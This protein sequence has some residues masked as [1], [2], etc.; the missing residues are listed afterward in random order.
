MSWGPSA[1]PYDV[2]TSLRRGYDRAHV[3][4]KVYKIGGA[5]VVLAF[6]VELSI[7]SERE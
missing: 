3:V 1:V 6:V 2:K 4:F 7:G 5:F